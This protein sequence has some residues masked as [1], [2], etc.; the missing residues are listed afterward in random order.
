MKITFEL[1]PKMTGINE[2]LIL[3]NLKTLENIWDISV[4]SDLAGVSFEYKRWA[5]LVLVRRELHVL[6]Y[7]IINDTHWFDNSENAL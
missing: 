6:G 7:H 3:E 2:K 1:R 5:V 4:D